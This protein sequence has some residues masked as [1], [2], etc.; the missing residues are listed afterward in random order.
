MLIRMHEYRLW[1]LSYL[2]ALIGVSITPLFD[3]VTVT[4]GYD[5]SKHRLGLPLPIIEQHTSLEPLPDA[6]PFELGFV[7]PQEHP[8]ELLRGNYLLLVFL[9][10]FIVYFSFFAIK[11]IIGKIQFK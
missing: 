8:T 11:W 3:S 7:S 10:W 1:L 9:A 6:F 2:I 5:L 4:S